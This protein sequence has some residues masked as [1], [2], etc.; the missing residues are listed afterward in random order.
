MLLKAGS[1]GHAPQSQETQ[2]VVSKW[3]SSSLGFRDKGL[4]VTSLG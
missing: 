3:H 2:E 4:G 1:F